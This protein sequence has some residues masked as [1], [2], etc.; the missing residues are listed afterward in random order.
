[1]PGTHTDVYIH[2]VWSTWDRI[3]LLR[4]ESERVAY[5]CICAECAAL[6]VEVLAIG[7]VEDHVHLL[8]RMPATISLA[9]LMNQVKGASSHLLTHRTGN[10]AFRWQGGYGAYS[11]SR[12]HV[13]VVKQYVEHQKTHHSDGTLDPFLEQASV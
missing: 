3:P 2:L 6:K 5:A 13:P 12:Q 7:G 10:D 4:G 11:I 8:V 1:M 9:T